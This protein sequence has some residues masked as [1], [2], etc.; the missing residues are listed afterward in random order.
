MR[1]RQI[2]FRLTENEYR[3]LRVEADKYGLTAA[4]AARL[5]TLESLAL[6]ARLAAIEQAVRALPDRPAMTEAFTK[7]A[8][9]LPKT[10]P[11]G[12]AQ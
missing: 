7:L 4:A 1:R 3:D 11:I 6:N 2:T 10:A 8:A 12:G 5:R 9:R